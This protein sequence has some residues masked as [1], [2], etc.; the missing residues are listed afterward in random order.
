MAGEIVE[1]VVRFIVSEIVESPEDV[2]VDLLEDGPDE[3]VA[4]V[5]TAKTD[6]GRVIGRRGRVARA[7]RTLAQAAGDEEG[8]KANVEFLD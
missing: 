6:M 7:I 4:E 2:Q 8:L 3:V 1:K 5:K